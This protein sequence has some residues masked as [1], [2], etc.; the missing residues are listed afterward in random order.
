MREHVRIGA[1]SLA[2]SSQPLFHVASEIT[3]A[4][5]ERW[6]GRGYVHGLSGAQIPLAGRIVA[7]IDVFD[8][9]THPRPYKDAWPVDR[10]LAEIRRGAGNRFDPDVVAA[11]ETIDAELLLADTTD[12]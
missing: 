4:H 3:L 12:L 2:S 8:A 11:F 10:A 5:H 9:L 7:V 1:S 6:D